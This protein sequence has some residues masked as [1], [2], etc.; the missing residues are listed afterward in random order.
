[1]KEECERTAAAKKQLE[2]RCGLL[3]KDNDLLRGQITN[4]SSAQE[5]IH[6]EEWFI[7]QFSQIGRDI[8]WW[9]AKETR[10]KPSEPLSA[11]DQQG[12]LDSLNSW[13]AVGKRTVEM[14][15][16]ELADMYQDRRKKITLIRHIVAILLCE[17]VFHPFSFGL[18]PEKSEYLKQIEI[19]VC[20]HGS[21]PTLDHTDR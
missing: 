8:E 20:L 15:G 14:L 12:L 11:A 18:G 10:V 16:S 19:D 21:N 9:A 17:D 2:E 4:M 5:P 3:E 1:M 7:L 13:G 6:E